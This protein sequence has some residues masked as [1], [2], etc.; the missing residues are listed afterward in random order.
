MT[1]FTEE[2]LRRKTISPN[3][4]PAVC[5][6]ETTLIKTEQTRTKLGDYRSFSWILDKC[7]YQFYVCTNQEY[8]NE[9]FLVNTEQIQKEN[10]DRVGD[11]CYISNNLYIAFY[12]SCVI[13]MKRLLE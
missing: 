12:Q 8:S 4:I 5:S 11:F 6:S 7:L 13:I 1:T 9:T 3:T 10:K 2:F